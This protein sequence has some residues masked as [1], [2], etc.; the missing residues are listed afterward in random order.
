MIVS[1]DWLRISSW[2][3]RVLAGQLILLSSGLRAAARAEPAS[4]TG[5]QMTVEISGEAGVRSLGS[6]TSSSPALTRPAVCRGKKESRRGNLN[7]GVNHRNMPCTFKDIMQ[8]FVSNY[9][10]FGLSGDCG[11]HIMWEHLNCWALFRYLLLRKPLAGCSGSRLL[12][13]GLRLWRL[14][15]DETLPR[16]LRTGTRLPG[17]SSCHQQVFWISGSEE[18]L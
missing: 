8:Y 18:A 13:R 4:R 5:F 1:I 7:F 2:A 12:R 6:G 3:M 16:V 14:E 15:C 17:T 10:P 9:H 11:Y